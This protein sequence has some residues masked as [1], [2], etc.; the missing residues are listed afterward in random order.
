MKSGRI[1]WGT[2]F[3]VLG[4]L[5]L[6]DNFWSLDLPW[7]DI[8]RFWPV[9][10]ILIGISA[11]TKGKEYRWLFNAGIAL[12]AGFVLFASVQNGCTH[13]KGV[14]HGNGD[15]FTNVLK[16]SYD[17]TIER[18]SFRID[19]GAG[20]YVIRDTSSELI[21][22]KTRTSFGSYVLRRD[23]TDSATSL[24]LAIK[25]QHI[26][27]RGGKFKNSVLISLNPDPLWTMDLNLGAAVV[28]LDLS[29]YLIEELNLDAGAAA[30]DLKLGSLHDN[31]K[32]TIDAGASAISILVPESLG[33]QINSDAELSSK[34]F[35]G[36]NKVNGKLFQTENF[37]T[38]MKRIYIDID[39]GISSI[40]VHQYKDS[41][42]LFYG[43]D[44]SVSDSTTV[45]F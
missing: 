28:D 27:W 11:L 10:L 24:E 16:S 13:V 31:T 23:D 35:S 7:G 30:I 43:P 29:A 37:T 19:G 12:I 6:L 18:A 4:A 44:S 22:A 1:F 32:V 40:E 9:V 38:A 15:V 21:T 26:S 14:F 2:L 41:E 25:E 36:F 8:W 5:I 33:C 20:K 42:I 3:V 39:A 17:S 34:T 45:V